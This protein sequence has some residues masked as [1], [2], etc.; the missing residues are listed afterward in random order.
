MSDGVCQNSSRMNTKKLFERIR[1]Q[2]AEEED[3]LPVQLDFTAPAIERLNTPQSI[4]PISRREQFLLMVFS[5][6]LAYDIQHGTHDAQAI[7][8]VAWQIEEQKIPPNVHNAAKC[9]LNF[10]RSNKAMPHKWMLIGIEQE[11]AK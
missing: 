9:F 4:A 7:A 5:G 1:K 2:R 11:I 3:G 6:A 10:F 8:G